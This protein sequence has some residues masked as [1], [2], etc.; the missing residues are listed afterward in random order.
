[1]VK[2][3][4]SILFVG[5]NSRV[6]A[7][8]RN[9]GEIVWKWRAPR[10]MRGYVSLLLLDGHRLIASVN[11]YT[12]CLDA[13]TGEQYWSNE[14][15]GFGWGV[16]SIAAVGKHNPHDPLV[17]AAA[18]NAAAAAAAAGGGGAGA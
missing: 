1:M 16:T 6:A 9:T 18:A 14:L 10:P 5:L 3:I 12:Y 8:H 15:T 4:D 7:L 13:R 17:A 2:D 11:G